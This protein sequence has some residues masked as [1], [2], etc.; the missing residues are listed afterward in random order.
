MT[1]T[2]V[3]FFRNLNVGQRGSPSRDQLL[4]AFASAGATDVL[5]HQ[6]NGTVAFT[7]PGDPRE[8]A[9]AVA[10]RLATV[11][12]YADL[13]VVRP[14]AWLRVLSLE[15]LPDGCELTLYDGPEAFPE[16][17]PFFHERAAATILAADGTH[18]IVHNHVDRRS[19]GTP[20]LEKLLGVP[21]TSRGAGTVLRLLDR[22][23]RG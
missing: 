9:D 3:A 15:D 16:Q 17:L 13:T 4:A 18:A 21:A 19:N 22:L 20:L 7:A 5:S 10:E 12:D 14:V 8:L 6:S 23:G 2:S 11:C 1:A